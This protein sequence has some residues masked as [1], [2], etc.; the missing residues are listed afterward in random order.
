M[1]RITGDNEGMAL[2]WVDELE[3]LGVGGKPKKSERLI[4]V[5]GKVSIPLLQ[6]GTMK[7]VKNV[8]SDGKL[9]ILSTSAPHIISTKAVV[10]LWGH[11]GRCQISVRPA[12]K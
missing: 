3:Y 11:Y 10:E 1:T 6:R 7:I 12:E 8:M 4:N 2:L 5:N 9:I